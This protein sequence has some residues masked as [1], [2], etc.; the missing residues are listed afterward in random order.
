VSGALATA[1]VEELRDRHVA[2]A[3]GIVEFAVGEQATVR[4]NPRYMEFELD[5][6][7]EGGSERGMFGFTRRVLQDRAPSLAANL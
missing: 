6:A 7:I 2:K 5:T 1:A 4:G 3:E